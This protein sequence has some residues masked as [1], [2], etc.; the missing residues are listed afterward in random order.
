MPTQDGADEAALERSYSGLQPIEISAAERLLREAKQVLDELGVPFFLRQG[1]C[2]GAIRDKGFIP[3][4]DDLD[5]GSIIGRQGISEE[6]IEE[7][8]AAFRDRGY[9]AKIERN[10]YSISAS[11][12]KSSIRMDWT[13]YRVIDDKII[14]FPGVPMPARLFTQ[15]MEIDFI[16]EKFHVPNPPEEY[17]RLKYGADWMVPKKTGYEK[18]IIEMIPETLLSDRA[19]SWRKFLDKHVLRWRSSR[20]RVLD[21][22]EKPVS[23]ADVVVAGVGR[24]KTDKLG[25]AKFNVPCND[26][27]ALVVRRDDH[28]EVLYMERIAQGKTYVYRPDPLTDSGRLTVLSEE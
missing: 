13:C 9:F 6:S 3:W 22:E 1:T 19:S 27:Y 14:H 26:W 16:G 24:F 28:E 8:V 5:L 20:L 17:L 15:L 4:D 18:E 11:M 23:D 7:V 12:I 25:Y 10:D 21:H 2:L